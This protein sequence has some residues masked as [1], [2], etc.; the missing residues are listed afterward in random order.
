MKK[1]SENK[2]FTLIELIIVMAIM[3]IL[4]G[5]VGTQVI[6]YLEKAREAKDLQIVNSFSTAAVATYS[7]NAEKLT[8]DEYK[9]ELY[10][11]TPVEGTDSGILYSGI[12]EL[13][14][15]AKL[16]DVQAQ[17]KS[18]KA[19]GQL[20]EIVITIDPKTSGTVEAYA[21]GKAGGNLFGE[22]VTTYIGKNP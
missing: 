8:K 17:M 15:Y 5:I 1:K 18:K 4:L 3:A 21:S 10:S 16:S 19:S 14:G 7:M 6:P 12:L 2:G 22:T 20:A 11:I 9:L 13:T